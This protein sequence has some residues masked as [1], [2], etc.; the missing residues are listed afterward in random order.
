MSAKWRQVKAWDDAHLTG[1]LLPVKWVLRALSSITLAVILLILVALYGVSASVPLGMLVMVPSYAL[2]GVT[3]LLTIALV[4]GLPAWLIRLM[5]RTGGK[6]GGVFLRFVLPLLCFVVLIPVAWALWRRFLWPELHYDPATGRGLKFFADLAFEYQA[7]TLRRLPGLEMSELEYYSWWPLRL[8]LLLFVVNMV[9]A[10]VR[11]I[12]FNFKNIGVLTVHTGIITIALGSVYYNGLKLE[13]DTLLRAGAPDASG[14]LTIGPTQHVFYDNTSVALYVAEGWDASK[15]PTWDMRRLSGVPRY[16]EY[17]L[18]ITRGEVASA[19]AGQRLGNVDPNPRRLDVPVPTG[20]NLVDENIKFRIV[21]YAPYATSA[22]D[23]QR[24]DPRDRVGVS[25]ERPLNPLRILYLHSEL[26]NDEGVARPE[27]P[28]LAFTLAPRLPAERVSQARGFLAIEYTTGPDGGMPPDRWRDLTSPL[29]DGAE[30]GLVVEV[31]PTPPA[32]NGF[33]TV[34]AAAPGQ[35]FRVGETGYSILVKQLLAEPPF[36]IITEGYRGASSSVAVL[37]ITTPDGRTFERFV[38]HRFPEISQ[39]VAGSQADG[40]PARTSTDPAIRTGLIEADTLQVYIDEPDALE[41][42]GLI[43]AIVRQAGGAVRVI[44]DLSTE[45]AIAGAKPLGRNGADA[46]I[47]D[48]VPK[49]SLRIGERWEDSERIERPIA[50]DP[51]ERDRQFNGTHDKAM[52]AVEVSVARDAL[53]RT[54][55]PAGASAATAGQEDAVWSRVIWVPFSRYLGID[56]S[57]ERLLWLPDGRHLR[58][59]FGREQ[60]PLPGF[61]IALLDFQMIAYDHRGSP[62]DYQSV[63]RVKPTEREFEGFDHV[64]RLNAPLTAP[65][66]WRDDRSWISN[67]AGRLASGLDP[68]QFKF[69]QAGWDADGW[70][71]S[72]TQA[73]AGLVPRPFVRYTV[74]GVGNNP[75]IHVVALGGILM[76]L[77]I[78]WAFYIKPWLVQREKK[79]I[80][81]QLKAG[82]YK[83]PVRAGAP[84]AGS[85]PREAGPA[86]APSGSPALEEAGVS[87]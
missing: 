29:P 71:Q 87:R 56:N 81:A 64:T 11:R 12:E 42:P 37:E 5:G 31:P 39:D 41:K 18:G 14:N 36:P 53:I 78:P 43:R 30:W 67:V 58:L 82:T 50:V 34:I 79:R 26:P 6:T 83:K 74:L 60:H 19:V 47:R 4:A 21:G 45:A 3:I 61:E 8:I 86:P 23:W 75:G 59:S 85:T 22:E 48:L 32:T 25:L 15:R 73:D 24:L 65:W 49:I 33:R 54:G 7:I 80:Q 84:N 2:Y 69:S 70:E 52:I 63:V 38:Y 17:D 55:G 28:L 57:M 20:F 35:R 68:T 77:G 66:I 40:R 51:K 13:G 46:W 27:A 44:E 1:A 10:T 76:G 16:N 72:Q 62:R 9:V